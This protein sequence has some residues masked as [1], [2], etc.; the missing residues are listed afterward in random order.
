MIAATGVS[1]G[2]FEANGNLADDF[3]LLHEDLWMGMETYEKAHR[4]MV[5][6]AMKTA[7]TKANVLKE[8]V[9][10]IMAGDLINQITPTSF[11]ART[12]QVPYFGLFSACATSM[13]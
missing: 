10:F 5:V 3:D 11:S 12:M 13:E 4:V 7:L 9:Q 6:E 2:P 8:K 1:G